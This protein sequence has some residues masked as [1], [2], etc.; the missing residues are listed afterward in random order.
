VYFKDAI[1]QKDRAHKDKEGFHRCYSRLS[2]T[3]TLSGRD[4]KDFE[5]EKLASGLRPSEAKLKTRE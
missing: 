5:S 3:E 4:K 1:D 2:P